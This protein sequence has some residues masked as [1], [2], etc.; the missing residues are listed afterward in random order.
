MAEYETRE[1]NIDGV[2][3][4]LW[5][6]EDTGLWTGPM[7]NWREH[8]KLKILKYTKHFRVAVQAGG[9]CGMYPRLLSKIFNTVYTFEPS[10]ISFHC[11][12]NNCPGPKIIKLNA[13]VGATPGLV[14]MNFGKEVNIGT[15]KVEER[16]NSS[17]P[18]MT[19]D[20]IP[21]QYCDL[22]MLDV[23][24]YE[25]EALK[26]AVNT[27]KNHKPILFVERGVRYEDFI[28]GIGYKKID[29]AAQDVIY[30]PEE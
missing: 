10:D 30:G 26:G 6:K 8:H 4:W 11:L 14:S 18:R 28:H 7:E 12:V 19:I 13:A 15:N 27:I 3:K 2:E 20:S 22:L 21:Y 24:G 29:T 1:E 23:E 5:V 17:I 25:G 16:E 9:G